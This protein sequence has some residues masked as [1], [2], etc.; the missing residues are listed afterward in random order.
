[1]V[2]EAEIGSGAKREFP[3]YRLTRDGFS[4]LAM[5]FTGKKA[6]AWKEKFLMAFNAMERRLTAQ[7]RCRPWSRTTCGSS[8]SSKSCAA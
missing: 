1:M 4:F 6:A 7:G 2:Y 8:A 5:G 3:A